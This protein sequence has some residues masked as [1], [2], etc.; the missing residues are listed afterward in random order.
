MVESMLDT[1]R[2]L[3][4]LSRRRAR[5]LV[6][7]YTKVTIRR[8]PAQGMRIGLHLSSNNYRAGDVEVPV[9]EAIASAMRPGAVFYDIG[10]NVGFFTLVAAGAVQ[11]RGTFVAFEARAD[12]A[13]RLAQN[14]AL[15][16][17]D[18][19]VWP[20]AVSDRSGP[21]ELL[22][23]EHPGGATIESDK[24]VDTVDTA[25]IEAVTIDELVDDGRLPAPDLVK[26]DVEGA[27]PAVIRGMTNTL[28]NANAVVVY[29]IDAPTADLA[30]ERFGEVD[31]LLTG[32]GYASDRLAPSYENSGWHVIHAIATPRGVTNETWDD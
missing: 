25:R 32:L 24:A 10:A 27:E 4:R 2:T 13:D 7:R 9:Q 14:M 21:I 23:A 19:S 16:D 1:V 20:V 6:R 31:G 11:G 22:V 5:R 15:N 28:R 26:I 3:A 12:V 8:G 29:E 18:V 17:L 30:E